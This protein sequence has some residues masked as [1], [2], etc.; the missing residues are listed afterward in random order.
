MK[1]NIRHVHASNDEWVRVHR[2]PAPPSSGNDALWR[3]ALKVGGGIALFFIVCQII[4]AMLPFLVLGALG[5]VALKF[6]SR[7]GAR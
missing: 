5:W 1:R 3:L 6:F 4:K 2:Q 7:K